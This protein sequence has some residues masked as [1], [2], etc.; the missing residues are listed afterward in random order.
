MVTLMRVVVV[1]I[2]ALVIAVV[3]VVVFLEFEPDPLEV[4]PQINFSMKTVYCQTTVS[5]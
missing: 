4:D 5:V 1:V 2:A 3:D